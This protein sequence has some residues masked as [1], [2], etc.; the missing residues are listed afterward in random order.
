MESKVYAESIIDAVSLSDDV[1]V[2]NA[3]SENYYVLRNTQMPAVLVEMG[4]LS[5][6]S[7]CHKL[8][9]DDYQETLP[10]KIADDVKA[11]GLADR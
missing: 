3:K 10:Q 2:R 8:L 5:N 6:Y 9:S 7:E 11:V 1:K 4:F